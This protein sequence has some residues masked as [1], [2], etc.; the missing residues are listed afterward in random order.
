MR[1]VHS[2]PEEL[3]CWATSPACHLLH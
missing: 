3:P 2:K 1:T